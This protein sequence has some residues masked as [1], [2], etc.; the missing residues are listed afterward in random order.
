VLAAQILLVGLA[1]DGVGG[2]VHA[3]LYGIGRPGLSSLAIGAG[4]VVTAVLDLALIP[5][6][7]MVGAAVASAC[8][9]LTAAAALLACFRFATPRAPAGGG[10]SI[11]AEV[12]PR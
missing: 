9:Y 11:A 7:G 5:S 3:F 10:V 2:V 8:A 12:T 1:A 6:H 4:L